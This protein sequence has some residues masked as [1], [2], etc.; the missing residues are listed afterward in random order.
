M[1]APDGRC[2]LIF[3]NVGSMFSLSLVPDRRPA[4][5]VALLFTGS[6]PLVIARYAARP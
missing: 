1:D 6:G 2:D 3:V 5:K 4:M